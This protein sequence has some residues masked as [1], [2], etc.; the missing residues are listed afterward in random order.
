VA[1]H[2]VAGQRSRERAHGPVLVA[3]GLEPLLD[4]RIRSGEG[5][6]ACLAA[7]VLS[8]A[9]EIRRSTGTTS[10]GPS[11]EDLAPPRAGQPGSDSCPGST[12]RPR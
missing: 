2:L 5:A 11:S 3:L 9:L 8:A 4:L 6:G 12:P 1:A 7:G 10:E